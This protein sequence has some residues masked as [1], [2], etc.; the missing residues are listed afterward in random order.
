VYR[1][2]LGSEEERAAQLG[3][4]IASLEQKIA[5]LQ[6]ARFAIERESRHGR[7][8]VLLRWWAVGLVVAALGGGLLIGNQ[9]GLRERTRIDN[10]EATP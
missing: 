1:D 4:E 7:L 9:L 8:G 2:S 5:A 6:A 3:R 10:C